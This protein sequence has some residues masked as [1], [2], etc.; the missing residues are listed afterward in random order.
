MISGSESPSV[1]NTVNTSTQATSNNVDTPK[2]PSVFKAAEP[3]EISSLSIL[4]PPKNINDYFHYKENFVDKTTVD[5]LSAELESLNFDKKAPN[6]D[7]QNQFISTFSESYVWQSSKGPVINRAINIESFPVVKQVMSQI[8][9]EYNC[10]M[11]CALVTYYKNGCVRN[12]LHKDNEDSLDQTQPICVVSV[13]VKRKVEFLNNTKEGYRS[14]DLSVEPDNASIYLMEAGCQQ[15]FRHRVRKDKRIRN[16]RISISFRC[17]VPEADKISSKSPAQA[18]ANVGSTPAPAVS[19]TPMA[20]KSVTFSPQIGYSPFTS[21]DKDDPP[22]TSARSNV[23]ERLCILL[24]TSITQDVDA[25]R[26][27]RGNRTVVNLSG[28]GFR[29]CDVGMAANDF[30]VEN[31]DSVNRV[32]KI[33]LNVGTNEIKFFNSKAKNVSRTFWSP[34]AKLVKQLKSLFPNAQIVILCLLPMRIYYTYTAA[35]IFHFNRLLYKICR[36]FGCI[37]YEDCFNHFLDYEGYDI[38]S[39]LYRDKWHLNDAGLRILCR[40]LKYIVLNNLFNPNANF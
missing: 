5:L 17:F 35:S 10:N 7:Y 38:N 40:S 15:Y 2:R 20:N 24:G 1:D 19:S 4:Q 22:T 13:G 3:H 9:T 28:S 33:I 30:Y 39:E 31:T 29:I 8:N 37:F 12:R 21:S 14:P 16:D 32:D 6:D 36:N 27:G 34:L 26:L 25:A 11:N 18:T 23:S